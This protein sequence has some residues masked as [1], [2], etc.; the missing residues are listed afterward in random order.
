MPKCCEFRKSGVDYRES[1]NTVQFN[2]YCRQTYCYRTIK[3]WKPQRCKTVYYLDLYTKP[4]S[5]FFLS[6]SSAKMTD[7]SKK[8]TFLSFSLFEWLTRKVSCR[9]SLPWAERRPLK[10]TKISI[11]S[12]LLLIRTVVP[13]LFNV[14][15]PQ[16]YHNSFSH[17]L[18]YMQSPKQLI[19]NQV[20]N[21]ILKTPSHHPKCCIVRT[22]RLGNFR[23]HVF[24][25]RS[26]SGGR[27]LIF[28][29]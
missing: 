28:P 8:K 18:Q 7:C 27:F 13:K 3:S 21:K 24:L 6:T 4:L 1:G 12:R 2:K 25:T 5:S 14:L 9:R 10:S 16:K 17:L 19:I 29:S 22:S 15:H 26:N 11:N 20:Q 23:G